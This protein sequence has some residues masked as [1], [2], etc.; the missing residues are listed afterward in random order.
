L[1]NSYF[2]VLSNSQMEE[3]EGMILGARR[4]GKGDLGDNA[5][6][7]LGAYKEMLEM[8]AR[9]VLPDGAQQ[10]QDLAVSEHDFHAEDTGVERPITEETNPAR[11]RGNIPSDHT[12]P[13]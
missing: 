4:D 5:Q 2:K 8:V 9:V 10:I 1:E 6:R 7:A 12:A 3:C 11:I 13:F